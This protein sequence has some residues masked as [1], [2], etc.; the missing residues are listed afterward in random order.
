[1]TSKLSFPRLPFSW[2]I[3]HKKSETSSIGVHGYTHSMKQPRSSSLRGLSGIVN[4]P[5]FPRKSTSSASIRSGSGFTQLGS[6]GGGRRTGLKL[7]RIIPIGEDWALSGG[8]PRD[9]WSSCVGGEVR[10]A[11]SA[12][13][14]GTDDQHPHKR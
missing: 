7:R 9:A 2:E 8:I 12:V 5:F 6:G 3:V 10:R 4:A 14:S 1:M 13:W 11:R